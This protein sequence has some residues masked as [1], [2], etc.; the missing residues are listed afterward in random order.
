MTTPT[1][2]E[3]A[4]QLLVRYSKSRFQ[5]K[6]EG[7]FKVLHGY[8]EPISFFMSDRYLVLVLLSLRGRG[9]RGKGREE[10]GGRRREGEREGGGG[11]RGSYL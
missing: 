5:V 1:I 9:G 6:G 7:V 8:L 2:I 10:G 3:I 4:V 11:R